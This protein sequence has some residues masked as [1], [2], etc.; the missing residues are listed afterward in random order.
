[1]NRLAVGPGDDARHLDVHPCPPVHQLPGRSLLQRGIK[2][3]DRYARLCNVADLGSNHLCLAPVVVAVK[4]ERHGRL[5]R[6]CYRGDV[7]RAGRVVT[8]LE[9]S[10]WS[11]HSR[12]PARHVL[13]KVDDERV[14]SPRDDLET[15]IEDSP[16]HCRRDLADA[17]TSY[18]LEPSG[19]DRIAFDKS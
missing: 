19:D 7:D 14:V 9:V 12:V 5:G 18:L 2:L 1:M 13:I 6:I 15:G 10:V 4:T 16:V 8:P 17:T 11:K 3:P